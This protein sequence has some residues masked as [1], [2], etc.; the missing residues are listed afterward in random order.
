MAI[1]QKGDVYTL[2]GGNKLYPPDEPFGPDDITGAILLSAARHVTFEAWEA[3]QHVA[4][5]LDPTP[6]PLGYHFILADTIQIGSMSNPEVVGI[7]V[8]AHLNK[9][10]VADDLRERFGV[11]TALFTAPCERARRLS[12][13]L[14]HGNDI[15]PASVAWLREHIR[16]CEHCRTLPDT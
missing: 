13:T 11:R 7:F 9:K 6:T 2:T 5:F 12:N 3:A 15:T 14:G 10:L 1:H 4:Y 16:S 8:P